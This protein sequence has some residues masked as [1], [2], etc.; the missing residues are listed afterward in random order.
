MKLKIGER[1]RGR[2]DENAERDAEAKMETDGE[3]EQGNERSTKR[4]EE[5]LRAHRLGE[6]NK[7]RK[8][9]DHTSKQQ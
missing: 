5:E 6:T 1:R 4:D 8:R 3:G 7:A 2:E 9:A